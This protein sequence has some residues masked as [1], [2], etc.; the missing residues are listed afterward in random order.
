[1]RSASDA[2][3]RSVL[4]PH[5][6]AARVDLLLGR[7][8]IAEG[9]QVVGGDVTFD[10]GAAIRSRCALSLR[11]PDRTVTA[12]G[13]ELR[14]WRGVTFPDGTPELLALGTFPVQS[15]RR[16]E[17]FG[18]VVATCLDRSQLVI[19]AK[20]EDTYVVASGTNYADAIEDLIAD[21]VDG[22]EFL[23]PTTTETTPLLTFDAGDD[24]WEAA[25]RM[26]RSLGNELL[27]DGLGRCVMRAEPTFAAEAVTTIGDGVNL[28]TVAEG[29]DR[30]PAFNKV[31]ATSSNSALGASYR[32]VA[33]DDDPASPTYYDGNFGRKPKF[34]PSEFIASQAQADA[35]AAAVLAAELG[36]AS[37]ADFTAAPDPRLETSDVVFVNNE[38]QG[39]S[40]LHI[41]ESLRI[42]VGPEGA[43]SG[44]LRS[45]EGVVTVE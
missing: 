45:Q 35:A 11:D 20:F 28:V 42:G 5:Q 8:V 22:L 39:I 12:Y 18:D 15:V 26:A 2:L 14:V 34:Y 27:F 24:R 7:V 21:G 38:R 25:R 29:Q 40:A 4:G 43:M 36:V 23:F 30:G 37:A 32:G 33:V 13:H 17:P 6:I 9:I 31:I 19:D 41:V 1:M 10:R 44:T 3:G 16:V